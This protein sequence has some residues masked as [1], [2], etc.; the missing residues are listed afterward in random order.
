MRFC[1]LA[2]FYESFLAPGRVFLTP[3][4]SIEISRVGQKAFTKYTQ[5]LRNILV[6]YFFILL[7]SPTNISVGRD[8]GSLM[9]QLKFGCLLVRQRRAFFQTWLRAQQKPHSDGGG[10]RRKHRV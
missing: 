10:A 2:H 6:F 9:C 3:F 1:E 4:F 8:L 7:F 5:I